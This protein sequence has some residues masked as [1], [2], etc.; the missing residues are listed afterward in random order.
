M[1]PGVVIEK[2]YTGRRLEQ[3]C[4]VK[5]NGKPLVFRRDLRNLCVANC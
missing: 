1:E 3:G 2:T 4:V 5:A